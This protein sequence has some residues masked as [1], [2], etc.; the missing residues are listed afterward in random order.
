MDYELN[1]RYLDEVAYWE[2]YND[3]TPPD[4]IWFRIDKIE[5]PRPRPRTIQS[6]IWSIQQPV[7]YRYRQMLN[8][9]T[10]CIP[11][12]YKPMYDTIRQNFPHI[13]IDDAIE[14][15]ILFSNES[16]KKVQEAYTT[17]LEIISRNK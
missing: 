1:Q 6:I 15:A 16:G 8:E 7:I 10:P 4:K 14:L 9:I 17:S 2:S 3:W 13:S 5:I 12:I 11:Y